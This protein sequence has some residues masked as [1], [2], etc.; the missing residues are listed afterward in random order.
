[1]I[2]AYHGPS[3]DVE[4]CYELGLLW[5]GAALDT[6]VVGQQTSNQNDD[7][8]ERS[9]SLQARSNLVRSSL[10]HYASDR[11][12]SDYEKHTTSGTLVSHDNE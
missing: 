6:D 10:E 3:L 2:V 9:E 7:L 8:I 12:F 4:S 5:I 1:M 11:A